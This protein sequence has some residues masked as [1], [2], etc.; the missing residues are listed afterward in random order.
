MSGGYVGL[1]LEPVSSRGGGRHPAGRAML[2]AGAPGAQPDRS[3][4]AA[5]GAE[6]V[7]ID[8]PA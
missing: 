3:D 5:G 2:D 1:G 7:R 6:W 4:A 8:T